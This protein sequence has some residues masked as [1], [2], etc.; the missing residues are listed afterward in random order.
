MISA[1]DPRVIAFLA[2]V[3]IV[4]ILLVRRGFVK[5]PD[6]RTGETWRDPLRM[7][8]GL[9][10][11]IFGV[12]FAGLLYLALTTVRDPHAQ[13]DMVA[14]PIRYASLAVGVVFLVFVLFAVLPALLNSLERFGFVP[15]VAA[16]HVRASKS[17]F[18][19]IISVLSISGVSVSSC[20]LCSVTSIM[21][22]FGYDLK[23]KI[24]RN[25]AHV[26]VDS[27]ASGGFT[28]WEE[29]VDRIRLGLGPNGAATPVVAGDA[30]SSS[31]TNTAGVLVRGI[32]PTTIGQVI[33]LEQNIDVGKFGYLTD[34][35]ALGKIPDGEVICR[36][37]DGSVRKKQNFEIYDGDPTIDPSV[38]LARKEPPARPGIILGRELAKSLH[39]CVG[40]E[41]SLLSPMGDL[42]PMGVM[43]RTRKFRVAGIFYS[44]M[45]EYDASHAYITLEEAQKFF[46]LEEKITQVDV[47]VSDPEKVTTFRPAIEAAVAATMQ[48]WKSVPDAP[49]LRVRDWQEM[50]KNLFSALLLERIATFMILS[51]AIAVASF[52]IICTLLLMVTEKG[53][54]I[55]VM[56]ALGASEGHIRKIFMIEGI[57]IGAIGTLFGV[58]IALAACTGLKWFGARLPPEV[59]Y[60]DRLPVNVDIADYSIVALASLAICTLATIYPAHAAARLHPV[61]GLRHE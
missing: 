1:S 31:A 23:Q 35:E 58:G 40:D 22:G 9:G 21:G 15:Y 53:R 56:K 27:G 5:I 18:L 4:S 13:F 51:I 17:G 29:V 41:M 19:T 55:A 33:D 36:L 34:T 45:Y 28:D 44:G 59:Y 30:M 11:G 25:Y 48:E 39:V 7:V 26:V 2:V 49:E 32:D 20:A 38:K 3:G 43:P 14:D 60:I 61:E 24:L 6:P 16:R 8:I 57:I 10:G 46:G 52:C 50:N 42:G 12:A 37:P 54:Q 47:R